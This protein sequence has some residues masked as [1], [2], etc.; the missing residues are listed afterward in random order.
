MARLHG[1]GQVMRAEADP[2]EDA[3]GKAVVFAHGQDGLH[4]AA[5]QRAEIAGICLERDVARRI[6]HMVEQLFAQGGESALA[7]GVLIRRH[8]VEAG[9]RL[10]KP[11][12]LQ[13]LFRRLLQIGVDD[14]DELAF[15]ALHP[16]VHGRLFAEIAGKIDQL[17]RHVGLFLQRG[18]A[19]P[20]IVAA[21][22][23][24]EDQLV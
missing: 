23:V 9:V 4:H 18:Q 11:H 6:D 24:D 1:V 21:A 13:R 5:A 16:G 15:G 20:R 10:Q 19:R 7:P 8:G 17:D 22:V 3:L 14:G 12:H 2:R